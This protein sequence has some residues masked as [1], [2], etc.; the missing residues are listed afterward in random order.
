MR[1]LP[2]DKRGIWVEKTKSYENQLAKLQQDIN[3]AISS[4]ERDGP[5]GRPKQA[6]EMNAKEMTKAGIE[7][8]GQ[9]LQ[10]TARAKAAIATTIQIGTETFDVLKQQSEQLK[11]I[12]ENV[13]KVESNLKRADKQLRAFLRCAE[14][15]QTFH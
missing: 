15:C 12:D 13:D 4:A 3:W 5:G 11:G 10:S 9:S 1:E 2:P 7:I 6:D 8:Q 14:S